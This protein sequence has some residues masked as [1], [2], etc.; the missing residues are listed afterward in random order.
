MPAASLLFCEASQGEALP[1]LEPLL[2]AISRSRP[3]TFV[4][5]LVDGGSLG[6]FLLEKRVIDNLYLNAEDAGAFA[7]LQVALGKSCGN[8]REMNWL[9][10][11]AME[12]RWASDRANVGEDHS[13]VRL[14][15]LAY[16]NRQVAAVT[17]A[18]VA[19]EP[20][21]RE[22]VKTH[23]EHLYG[24]RGRVKGVASLAWRSFIETLH[25]NYGDNRLFHFNAS[26]LPS[27]AAIEVAQA[28][29]ELTVPWSFYGTPQL[30]LKDHLIA[31]FEDATVSAASPEWYS[32]FPALARNAQRGALAQAA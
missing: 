22:T 31:G 15:A 30:A 28:C 4:E 8:R 12:P 18:G 26:L 29:H 17:D 2:L 14:Q 6:L 1:R 20:A 32:N 21:F 27:A 9:A 25:T 16:V 3:L 19:T 13:S 11:W 7:F 24:L 5:P 23:I 10:K